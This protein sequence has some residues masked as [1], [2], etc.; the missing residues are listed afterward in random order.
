MR[1]GTIPFVQGFD[2]AG[3][4]P[5]AA[6]EAGM[7]T[8]ARVRPDTAPVDG[9]ASIAGVAA[10][11]V[12][13]TLTRRDTLLPFLVATF[14]RVRVMQALASASSSLAGRSEMKA[15][16]I[17]RLFARA[18][19]QDVQPVAETFVDRLVSSGLRPGTL[20]HVDAHRERG[21]RLVMVSAS[22]DVYLD[23]LAR[24]LGFDAVLATSLEIGP[25][26][27]FTGRMAR[28]NV[29]GD[30]KTVRL[31]EWMGDTTLEVWAYGNSR[32]DLALL[33][34]AHYPTWVGRRGWW[35]RTR[36]GHALEQSQGAL[37]HR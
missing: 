10:F 16:V 9:P 36:S 21:H 35:Y 3:G 13:G 18:R 26:G 27:C 24:R 29:R 12:D 1:A 19:P 20:S 31:R 28:G 14:G 30:E 8:A 4:D 25:D 37:R 17:E 6:P 32:N 5:P 11:D 15:R 34:F 23:V 7:W 33:A 2:V 22:L